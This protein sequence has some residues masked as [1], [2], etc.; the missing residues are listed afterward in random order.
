M[1][2]NLLFLP[3]H[4]EMAKQVFESYSGEEIHIG[5]VPGTGK[6]EVA[7]QLSEM[8][9]N[10]QNKISI[11]YS[12]DAYYKIPWQIRNYYRIGNIYNVGYNEIDWRKLK[13]DI[14]YDF[15]VCD[16]S[17][18]EGLY[19]TSLVDGYNVFLNGTAHNTYGFR[20][21]RA[22]ED[23]DDEIRQRIVKKE[24]EEVSKYRDKSNLI[25]E[26]RKE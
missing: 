21:E 6:T 19:A 25:I 5:G 12:L 22:K 11:V 4:E 20:K 14:A 24:C 10:E 15:S 16:I 7:Q 23:P 13:A 9:W 26:W 1:I 17:I 18:V 8:L 2:D 3:K